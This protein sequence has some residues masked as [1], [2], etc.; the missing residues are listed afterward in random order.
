M[1]NALYPVAV[2]LWWWGRPIPE[3]VRAEGS[4]PLGL[5]QMALYFGVLAWWLAPISAFL[6]GKPE[7]RELALRRFNGCYRFIALLLSAKLLLNMAQ[8]WFSFH[9][10]APDAAWT[11]FAVQH[12]LIE[13]FS[14]YYEVIFAVM[15]LEPLFFTK[16]AARFHEEPAIFERKEGVALTLR[17]KLLLLVVNLLLVP[18]ALVFLNIALPN[19]ENATSNVLLMIV[20]VSAYAIGYS[21]MLYRGVTQPLDALIEKMDALKKGDYSQRTTVLAGDEIGRLK[22]HFNEMAEGLGERERLRDT[23]GRYVSVEVAK[24]LM[25]SGGLRL[26]GESVEAT[27]LFSDIRDFTPLSESMPPQELVAFL[28]EYFAHVT[29]PLAAHNGVINKFIGDAV[30]VIFSPQFGSKEHAADAVAAAL[31]MGERLK[32]F[33]ASRPGKPAVRAGIGLHT[34]ALVA[35]NIGTAARLEYTVI[36]DTVNTASRIEGITKELDAALLISS[37]T[38]DALSAGRRGSLRLER[39]DGVRLKG[40]DRPLTLYKVSAA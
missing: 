40:K 39:V 25:E 3:L 15:Y 20:A 29:E 9:H 24:R 21:E 30:M 31:A 2:K 1:G 7:C 36:G 13:L 16:A 35:G 10:A 37:A 11:R 27:I 14:T 19:A 22:A 28:N 8:G 32:A 17:A 5:L 33:N 18:L 12:G 4:V 38:H 26:G 6:A 34:G 23:F